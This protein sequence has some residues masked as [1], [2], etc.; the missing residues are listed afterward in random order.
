MVPLPSERVTVGNPPFTCVGVD[1]M[2]QILVKR[3]CSQVKRFGCIFTCLATRA[4]HIEIAHALDTNAFLN[5]FSQFIARHGNVLKMVS[6]N[7][8]NSVGSERELH[9]EIRR[10]NQAYID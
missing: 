6:D 8:R 9:G 3:A 7:G 5:E 10:W 2:G 4:I 1:Y